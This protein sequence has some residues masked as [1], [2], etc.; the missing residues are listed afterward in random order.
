MSSQRFRMAFFIPDRFFRNI[1]ETNMTCLSQNFLFCLCPIAHFLM[2][3]FPYPPE[4]QLS[5]FGC[6]L[7]SIIEQPDA[8]VGVAACRVRCSYSAEICQSA[9]TVSFSRSRR[10]RVILV[11]HVDII[12]PMILRTD[13]CL[14]CHGGNQNWRSQARSQCAALRSPFRFIELAAARAVRKDT[15]WSGFLL[16]VP[17]MVRRVRRTYRISGSCGLFLPLYIHRLQR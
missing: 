1:H 3:W 2:R 6:R 12:C 14:A 15:S 11:I 8:A 4:L 9:E 5:I 16:S 7:Y 13:D 10:T 17:P